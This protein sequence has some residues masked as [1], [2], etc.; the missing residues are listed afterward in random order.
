MKHYILFLLIIASVFIFFSTRFVVQA[1]ENDLPASAAAFPIIDLKPKVSG[2]QRLSTSNLV[3][4]KVGDAREEDKSAIC[5][6]PAITG[7]IQP[8][9][10]VEA[11]KLVSEIKSQF[12]VDM[13]GAWNEQSLRWI[14]EGFYKWQQT[15]PKFMSFI[16]G[17]P[18]I[19]IPDVKNSNAYG[20]TVKIGQNV[21]DGNQFLGYLIHEFGHIIYHT[22]EGGGSFRIEGDNLLS[23][24]GPVTPY[25][26]GDVTENY[27]EMISYCLTRRPVKPLVSEQRWLEKYKPLAEK[28]IGPC[29]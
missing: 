28:I 19:L 24:V 22:K 12:G 21:V 7:A 27:P 6:Q 23:S 15:N 17:Q 8:P 25:G 4:V 20:N 5:N 9:P 29:L 1:Q 3:C 13:Q 2:P 18:V 10:T 16:S 26:E 11:G 14:Y